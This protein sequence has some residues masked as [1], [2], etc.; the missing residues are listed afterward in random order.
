M[1][2]QVT[3]ILHDAVTAGVSTKAAVDLKGA[4]IVHVEI[5]NTAGTYNATVNFWTSLDGTN[6]NVIGLVSKADTTTVATTAT[7]VGAWFGDIRGAAYFAT[8]ISAYVSGTISVKAGVYT[9]E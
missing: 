3:T 1:G 2:R 7:A 5:M 8:T 4:A 9:Q 6:W